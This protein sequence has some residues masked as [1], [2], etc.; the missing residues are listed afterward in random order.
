M[1]KEKAI[2]ESDPTKKKGGLKEL[3]NKK[4]HQPKKRWKNKRYLPF[5]C[6][7]FKLYFSIFITYI[8]FWF[9]QGKQLIL[10]KEKWNPS[11]NTTFYLQL[12]AIDSLM[13]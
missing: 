9:K 8:V 6:S 13:T 2:M 12:E 4:N 7:I 5:I 1:G 11:A 3:Q 10:P